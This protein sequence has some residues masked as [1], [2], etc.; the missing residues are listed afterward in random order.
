[1][2]IAGVSNLASADVTETK[3]NE[4]FRIIYITEKAEH[5]HAQNVTCWLFPAIWLIRL[6]GRFHIHLILFI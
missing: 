1:M 2:A 3:T 5:Q 6:T 4:G